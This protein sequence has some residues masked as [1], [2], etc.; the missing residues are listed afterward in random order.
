MTD[1]N[2]PCAGNAT[3]ACGGP[4]LLN[5]F[6]SGQALPSTNP[7]PAGWNLLGCYA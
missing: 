5:V 7:G 1:C 6:Y 4:Y 3:E 2:M